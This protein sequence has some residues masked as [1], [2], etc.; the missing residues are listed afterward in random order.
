MEC[1]LEEPLQRGLGGP[2]TLHRDGTL[3]GIRTRE[4]E[5]RGDLKS[6]AL[7]HNGILNRYIVLYKD[8]V[9]RI[10]R[11]SLNINLLYTERIFLRNT[12]TSLI[13]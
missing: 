8:L 6:S 13:C 3:H 2:S 12:S 10:T 4:I 5:T 1:T 7:T 9:S 11:V